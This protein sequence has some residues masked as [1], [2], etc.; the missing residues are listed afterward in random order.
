MRPKKYVAPV[1]GY[2]QRLA[3]RIGARVIVEPEWGIAAQI[4]FKNGKKRYI[5]YSSLDLNTLGSSDIAKDKDYSTFF[6]RKLG[7]STVEGKTFFSDQWAEMIGSNQK[8]EKAYAYAFKLGFPVIVK[9]NS[10]S[11]GQN[12]ALVHDKRTFYKALKRI[13]EFDKV[14][15]VQR[16]VSG[17]DYRIVVL[18]GEVISAYQRVPL[19]V[20]GNGTSSI[21]ALLKA[22]QKD[23]VKE[24]RD[25]R[26]KMDDPRILEKLAR[27]N[28]DINS[29]PKKDERVYLLDNANLSS[30]GDS[31]DVTSA[32]HKSVRKL[33]IQLTKDMGLRLCGVDMI[34]EGDIGAPLKKYWILEINAAPGLDHYAA[35]GT[36]QK[37]I[38]DDLYL[39]IL[40]SLS[41]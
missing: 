14:S 37:K 3:P 34:I 20:I 35:G 29:V 13:F 28:K 10:G 1:I 21:R 24:G 17:K 4:I 40:K 26:I 23:F 18:D 32:M 22:K 7:Y 15:L 39:Q 19:S 6:M 38:V 41:K 11:Q 8:I 2:M 33:A 30:G 36:A 12:V 27:E 25:T 16:P 31:L 9:P 5:R